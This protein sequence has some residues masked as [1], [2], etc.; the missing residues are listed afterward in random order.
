MKL[1]IELN[2][3]KLSPPFY[4]FIK[5]VLIL[6]IIINLITR[7]LRKIK[8][9]S[10]SLFFFKLLWLVDKNQEGY[11]LLKTNIIGLRLK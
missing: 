3:L 4:N 1:K 7:I 8:I 9:S 11:L 10:E 5:L 2:F 6:N